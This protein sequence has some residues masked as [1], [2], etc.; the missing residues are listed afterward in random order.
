MTADNLAIVFAPTLFRSAVKGAT[1]TLALMITDFGRVFPSSKPPQKAPQPQH[2]PVKQPQGPTP[3]VGGAGPTA[4]GRKLPPGAVA[5]L[6][7]MPK[8]VP[9][10]VSLKKTT[11]APNKGPGSAMAPNQTSSVPPL[12][13]VGSRPIPPSSPT[14]TSNAPT[15]EATPTPITPSKSSGPPQKPQPTAPVKA[16]PTPVAAAS[17]KEAAPAKEATPAPAKEVATSPPAT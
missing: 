5:L 7:S 6:P 9:G 10:E 15:K 13:A 2:L 1:E 4:G 17:S 16:A 8:I 12:K 3:G 14:P 11:P